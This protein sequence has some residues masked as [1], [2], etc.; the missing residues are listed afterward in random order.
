MSILRFFSIPYNHDRLLVDTL[1]NEFPH[2]SHALYEIFFPIPNRISSTGRTL[3]QNDDYDNEVMDLIK[4]AK[5]H[6]IISNILINPGCFGTSLLSS[7][8]FVRIIEYLRFHN[9]EYGLGAV[10]VSD[11]ILGRE[12][13]RAIPKI[14]L[15]CSSVA[16]VDTIQKAKYWEDIGCDILVIPPDLNKNIRFIEN[17]SSHL[18]NL[19][20]KMIVNQACIPQCPMKIAHNNLEGHN[21]DGQIYIDICEDIYRQKPWLFYSSSFIPPKRLKDYDDCISIYKLVDRKL[22]TNK[23]LRLIGAYC[24]DERYREKIDKWN[25]KIPDSVYEAIYQCDRNCGVC[26]LCEKVYKESNKKSC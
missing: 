23:I 13:K 25:S 1:L 8:F 3:K 18:P 12:I 15:E 26:N 19:K 10:T 16:Y 21:N 4:K 5:E 9:A 20:L 14:E 11:Y 6:N 22:P 24:T 17:L 7:D 2:F